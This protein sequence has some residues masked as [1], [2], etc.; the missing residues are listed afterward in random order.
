MQNYRRLL[1]YLI[2]LWPQ[3]LISVFCMVVFALLTAAVAFMVKPALDDIFINKDASMLKMLPVALILIFVLKGVANFFQTYYTGYVGNR[4][5][6]T[7]REEVYFH[8][9]KLSL[10]FFAAIPSGVLTSRII[11]DVAMIQ[12]AVSNV[13]AGLL[14]EIIT[15]LG[16][17]GVLVYRDWELSI[18]V[19][20]LFPLFFFPIFKYS[21][22]LRRFSKKSQAQ[23]AE[24]TAFLQESFTGIRVIKAFLMEEY[25]R[26]EF[27][28]INERLLGLILRRLKVKAL[29]VPI[30]ETAGGL[31]AA[32]VI[33]YGGSQVIQGTSTTGNF[34]SFMT[35]LFMLYG[36]IRSLNR[37]NNQI[38]EAL[39]AGK[40]VFELLDTEA[41][42][43]DH[44]NA[45]ELPF[46]QREIVY[47][48][49]YFSYQEEEEVIKGFSLQID[50]GEM[51]AIVGRSGSG[52]T[53]LLN[54]LPRFYE[55]G[56]G[57]ITIDGCDIRKVT[58]RSLRSAISIV[59]QH[60][61]LFNDTVRNNIVYGRSDVVQ[62]EV[63]AA[64]RSAN[65]H[66]F[67][68]KLPDKYDT[69][70][71]ENGI[72]LSGGQQQRLSIARALLKNSPILL[73]DEATSSLDTESERAVQEAIN[74]LMENRTSLVIA[75]RLSTIINADRIVV[76]ENGMLAEVG[77]HKELL[78][79]D[80]EYA[81]LYAL[82]FQDE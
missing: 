82:Q 60:T 16:L 63:V 75:H 80:G 49:V 68:E 69:V 76:L 37:S 81:R 19:L 48:N 42:I 21:R 29:T 3:L 10:S 9:Q 52:K 51:V 57:R 26:K 79:K 14:K 43:F 34:F 25:N 59:S 7:I 44:P 12:R 30:S 8:I 53:T 65:A 32:A 64:A 55:V 62:D 1:R 50:K 40:R 61:I 74:R 66:N 4:I 58:Q 15:A 31:A 67:I 77:T 47:E 23:V 73:L 78:E 22:K 17:V 54:L 72:R 33:W 71:G 46:L 70:I 38:Q 45:C 41:E 27:H 11:Y 18:I 36:P 35:A 6:T 39:A 13:I 5:I 2:P 56:G 28:L 24:I 20:F